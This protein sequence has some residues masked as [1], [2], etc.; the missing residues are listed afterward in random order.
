MKIKLKEGIAK[1][2]VFRSLVFQFPRLIDQV[3][4][5]EGILQAANKIRPLWRADVSQ[6]KEIKVLLRDILRK[7]FLN[8]LNRKSGHLVLSLLQ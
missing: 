7:N 3:V 5:E 6:G 8:L 1:L 4:V 2:M